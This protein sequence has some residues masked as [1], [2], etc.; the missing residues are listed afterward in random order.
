MD[1]FSP[2]ASMSAH[3]YMASLGVAA[4]ATSLLF[5]AC[6]SVVPETGRRQFI[7]M[8]P[9]EEQ[10][11]GLSTFQKLKSSNKTSGSTAQQA[12]VR[13]IGLR[14]A[15]VTPMRN[16]HWEFVVFQGSSPNA[17]CLPGGKVG[18]QTGIFKIATTDAELAAV[19]SHEVGHAV[20]R[21]S[22]EQVSQNEAV[23]LG[24]GILGT[25]VSVGA[26][27]VTGYAP[28]ADTVSGILGTGANLGFLLPFSRRQELE[29]DRLG[30]IYMARAGY[31][32]RAAIVFWQKMAAR[33]DAG[34]GPSF[35]S[36]HPVD[37]RRL[38]ELQ[39]FLPQAMA[40][41]ERATAR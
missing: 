8:S 34:D 33:R 27:A 18:V 29:A 14:I 22:A 6:T 7:T 9:Q 32:P 3:S 11:R 40:E 25:A 5:S 35:L 2:T 15:G 12:R 1:L 20:A 30:L 10:S 21:H 17:F 36:T 41:Y 38:A 37:A 24:V 26:S 4:C 31:D 23:G 16:A 39:K 28:S 13:R 19:L